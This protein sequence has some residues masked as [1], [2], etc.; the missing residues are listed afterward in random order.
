MKPTQA[1]LRLLVG[2]KDGGGI[3]DRYGR[4]IANGEIVGMYGTAT[5]LRCVAAGW[6]TGWDGRLLLTPIGYGLATKATNNT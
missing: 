5:A 6:V 4:V 3:V 2:L 1:Q